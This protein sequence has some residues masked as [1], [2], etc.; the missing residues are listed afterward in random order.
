MV[1]QDFQH[2][3]PPTIKELLLTIFLGFGW[4]DFVSP[5]WRC[6]EWQRVFLLTDWQIWMKRQQRG[7]LKLIYLIKSQVCGIQTNRLTVSRTFL[8]LWAYISLL[9]R[10]ASSHWRCW[11][12]YPS[13][14]ACLPFFWPCDTVADLLSR[15]YSFFSHSLKSQFY[16]F[17]ALY[18][19]RLLASVVFTILDGKLRGE[20]DQTF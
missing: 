18:I 17:R 14:K 20:L 3:S 7:I 11:N 12:L 8:T 16:F 2:Y 9:L 5:E 6:M 19:L 4:R 1:V 10:K 13:F 15:N